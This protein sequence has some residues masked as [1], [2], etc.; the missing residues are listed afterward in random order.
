MK[1]LGDIVGAKITRIRTFA[2]FLDATNFFNQTPPANFFPDPNQ[3]LPRDIYY[4]DRLANENKNFIQYELAQLFEVEGITLPGRIV[5]QAS[6]IWNYRGEGCLYEYSTRESY[7]HKG[8]SLPAYA[9]P[10]ATA[11]DEQ[12]STLITGVSFNDKGAY[13]LGQ[14]YNY[15]D[16]VYI[17]NRGIN[18]YFV[19]KVPNNNSTPPNNS[20]WIADDCSKRLI[21]CRARWQLLGSGILPFGGFPSVNRF[22]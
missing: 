13:N 10:V 6:C 3:E 11:L 15:G 21:G 17:N 5:S 7:V 18:Y 19:S 1:Q 4:I 12:I 20:G 14:I 8:A 9:P 22:S 16:S 2:R